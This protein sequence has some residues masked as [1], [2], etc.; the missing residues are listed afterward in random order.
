[1]SLTIKY[2]LCTL[3]YAVNM[4]S[5]IIYSVSGKLV[6]SN[7]TNLV[8]NDSVVQEFQYNTPKL[9]NFQNSGRLPTPININSIQ[10]IITNEGM[11]S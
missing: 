9:K 10:S 5:I 1:M 6:F 2:K 7:E 3:Y 8:V 11:I 4:C